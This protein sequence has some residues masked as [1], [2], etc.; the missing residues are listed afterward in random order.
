M[1]QADNILTLSSIQ[2]SLHVIVNKILDQIMKFGRQL[3]S[4]GREPRLM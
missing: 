4:P 3:V 2:D 1:P